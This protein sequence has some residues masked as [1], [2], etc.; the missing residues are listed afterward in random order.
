M[1]GVGSSIPDSVVFGVS[2]LSVHRRAGVSQETPFEAVAMYEHTIKQKPYA[3][4]KGGRLK[5][6]ICLWN[7]S[8]K[9]TS[10][11]E[12]VVI[13][14]L[15]DLIHGVQKQYSIL[16]LQSVNGLFSNQIQSDFGTAHLDSSVNTS[17]VGKQKMCY[18]YRYLQGCTHKKQLGFSPQ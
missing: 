4:K 15:V 10:E 7:N 3:P 16:G 12:T 5:R 9:C 13:A 14:Q 11:R 8:A 17:C 2:G 1:W 6:H 18:R